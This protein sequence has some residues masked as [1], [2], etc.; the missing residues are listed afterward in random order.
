[1]EGWD[2]RRQLTFTLLVGA[3]LSVSGCQ[4]PSLG[5]LAFWNRSGSSTAAPD[6]SK[7]RYDGFSQQLAGDDYR[8]AG[9][10]PSGSAP[11][12][13]A[14][15]SGDDNFLT[16]S[17]KKTTAAVSTAVA[18]K[19]KLTGPE[20]DPL[21]LDKLPKRIGPEVYVGA[22][23]LLENQGRNAEAEEKYREA[24]KAA[25]DDLS[26]L[27]GLARLYDR[28]GRGPKA[29]EV[30]EQARRAHP[31]SSLVCNDL[32]LC[33]LRQKQRE[34]SIQAF[35]AAVELQ[36]DNAKYRNNL[37]AALVDDGRDEEALRELSAVNTPAIAHFN[38]AYLLQERGRTADAVQHLQQAVRL[39]A[40]LTA[41]RE[42]LAQLGSTAAPASAPL[43]AAP[44]PA[45]QVAARRAAP[46]VA[47]AYAAGAADSA[48][49]TSAPQIA[50]PQTAAPAHAGSSTYRIS[51]DS[52]G[53]ELRLLPP[54]E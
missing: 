19:P 49:Y 15:S 38:L 7:Q 20:D 10:T 25:P 39:D 21:R 26:A 42:M 48:V 27:V 40:G 12:G 50:A 11:L 44:S 36:P 16:A 34:A 6:I 41:A 46:S 14:R 13:A 31:S 30:Y 35:R 24:L 2:M 51:D 8:P 28:D 45:T 18:V 47:P 22:A 23:R 53:D 54:T 29:I 3:G 17:W 4:A 32:G 37:A 43:D 33:Y 9:Q 52:S 1:M 5:S